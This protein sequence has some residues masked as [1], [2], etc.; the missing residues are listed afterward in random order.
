MYLIN[1][2]GVMY[3][4]PVSSM[5]MRL[6]HGP[7]NRSRCR[8]LLGGKSKRIRLQRQEVACLIFHFIFIQRPL[9]ET[10]NEQTPDARTAWLHDVR[11]TTPVIKVTDYADAAGIGCPYGK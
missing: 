11:V 7:Y 6:G 10:G 8:W 2:D 4:L 5:M 9:A 1:G 3:R